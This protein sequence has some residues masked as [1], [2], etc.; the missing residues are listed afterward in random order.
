MDINLSV[1]ETYE[2][3]VPNRRHEVWKMRRKKLKRK[4]SKKLFKKT[5]NRMHKRNSARTV[6]RGGIA[7]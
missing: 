2:N 6:P 3:L 5:A 7:L 4:A 1:L